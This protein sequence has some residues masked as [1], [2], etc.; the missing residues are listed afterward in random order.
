MAP[1]MWPLSRIPALRG[2]SA[3]LHVI[4]EPLDFTALA[5]PCAR[6][7]SASLHVTALAHPCARGISASLH[8]IAK[9]AALVPKPRVNLTRF[10]GVFAPNSQHRIQVTPAKRGKGKK[11]HA[12]DEPSDQAATERHAAMTPDQVRGRLW[13]QRLKRVFNIDIETCPECGGAVKIIA[14]IEDPVVIK[15]ILNHL[16]E[17]AAVTETIRLPECRAPPQP[18]VFELG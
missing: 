16:D 17:K 7:I 2:I 10:H 15:K 11:T 4:F 12:T 18:G 1:R 9:L 3:S 6:G 8:V 14:C 5:H 13:A